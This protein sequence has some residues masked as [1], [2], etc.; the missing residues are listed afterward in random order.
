M[1]PSILWDLYPKLGCHGT[2][3]VL[4]KYNH[5][6]K[7]IRRICMNG[8]IKPLFLGRLR[9]ERLT[10]NQMVGHLNWRHK[11]PIYFSQAPMGGGPYPPPTTLCAKTKPQVSCAVTTQLISVFVF[12][13]QIVQLF[14][15]LN[16]KNF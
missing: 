12:A 2:Q 1:S 3:N 11:Q 14:F 6:T 16:P 8:L 15:I 7:Q 10:S 13:T 5:P 4:R 9:L